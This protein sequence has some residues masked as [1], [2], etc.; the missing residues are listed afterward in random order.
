MI[1]AAKRPLTLNE[2]AE[3]ISITPGDTTWSNTKL[4]ND[5][6][7]FLESCGSCIIVDEELSTVHFAHSS[8]K[9]HLLSQPTDLDIQYNVHH[10]HISSSQADKNLGKIIVTYLN[11]DVLSTQ[12]TMSSGPSQ[13]YSASVPTF[14]ARSALPKGDMINKVALAM[15]RSRRASGKD[16]GRDVETS[17]NLMREKNIQIEQAFS[18]LSY[19]HQYWLHHSKLVHLEKDQTHKLWEL[20]VSGNVS[21]VEL[22]WAPENACELSTSGELGEQFV[23]WITEQCHPALIEKAIQTLWTHRAQ[24]VMA[25]DICYKQLDRLLTLRGFTS[26]APLSS[27]KAKELETLLWVS[28]RNGYQAIVQLL[29]REGVDVN[30]TPD[31]GHNALYTAISANQDAIAELFIEY[32]ADVN[33]KGGEYGTALQMAVV[34]GNDLVARLLLDKGADL[35][36][37]GGKHGTALI[38]A[39]AWGRVSIWELLLTAGADVNQAA[40]VLGLHNRLTPLMMAIEKNDS[41]CVKRLLDA[42]ADPNVQPS[43]VHSPLALAAKRRNEDMVSSLLRKGGLLRYGQKFPDNI[44]G[45][46]KDLRTTESIAVTLFLASTG[47]LTT[48]DSEYEVIEE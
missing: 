25:S 23:R 8:V 32:G 28:T 41:D 48:R 15:L 46:K 5:V 6:S 18:L 33:I 2:L 1:A 34:Q 42:G 14:V 19:C 12:L 44:K 26:G 16:P 3:A 47:D 11:L 43:G 4:V 20:L 31:G 40:D 45:F 9:R 38:A 30:A 27:L 17:A 21:T 35:N 39:V 24:R 7:K 10:Y 37:Q 29:L 22:P 13:H 36:A